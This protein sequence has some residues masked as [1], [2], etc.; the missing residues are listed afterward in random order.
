[1]QLW[2]TK[3]AA[4]AAAASSADTV[5][6]LSGVVAVSSLEQICSRSRDLMHL[7]RARNLTSSAT[8]AFELREAIAKFCKSRAAKQLL[9]EE[10][11]SRFLKMTA[12]VHDALESAAAI[13]KIDAGSREQL[14]QE[15]AN[16]HSE[17][18]ILAAIASDRA[19]ES[20]AYSK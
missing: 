16:I 9:N 15:V 2:R 20:N 7:I 4:E 13:R 17:M 6:R 1:V 14:L 10:V 19:G 18:S 5:R 3:K 8:A 11:W 12:Q